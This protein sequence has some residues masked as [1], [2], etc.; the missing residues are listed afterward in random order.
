LI[1]TADAK[2][3]KKELEK[4]LNHH[5]H[6]SLPH[7]PAF[8]GFVFIIFSKIQC[9]K[10]NNTNTLCTAWPGPGMIF[11]GSLG[12]RIQL[13]HMYG[14]YSLSLQYYDPLL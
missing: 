6:H 5:H 14:M 2:R 8:S 13:N 10:P 7:P 12:S 3:K 11:F 9:F 4:S 1:P